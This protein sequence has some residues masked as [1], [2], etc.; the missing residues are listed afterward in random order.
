[1]SIVYDP[2]LILSPV[3][4]ACVLN[5]A[6]LCFCHAS[7]YAKFT[8]GKPLFQISIFINSIDC[9]QTLDNYSSVIQIDSKKYL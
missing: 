6:L 1:M 3:T 7:G 8:P 5:R 9:C 2:G 4:S